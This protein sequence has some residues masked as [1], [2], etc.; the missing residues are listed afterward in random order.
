MGPAWPK[1][2]FHL[3]SATCSSPCPSAGPS[4][5]SICWSWH[6]HVGSNSAAPTSSG[7]AATASPSMSWR[8]PPG[9][10]PVAGANDQRVALQEAEAGPGSQQAL[11]LHAELSPGSGTNGTLAPL[12]EG[13][14]MLLNDGCGAICPCS[15]LGTWFCPCGV[16]FAF[17]GESHC[18]SP[19]GDGYGRSQVRA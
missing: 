12:S 11:S 7:V 10:R 1:H 16:C 14:R 5:G 2:D 9:P 4:P 17:C 6:C 15:D 19:C 8:A 3:F 13:R 18:C